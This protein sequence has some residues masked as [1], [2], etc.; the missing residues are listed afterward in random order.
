[1]EAIARFVDAVTTDAPLLA[2]AGDGLAVTRVLVAIEEAAA[3][4][5]AVSIGRA[6]A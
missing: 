1:M 6:G 2:D 5:R 3:S 4:G